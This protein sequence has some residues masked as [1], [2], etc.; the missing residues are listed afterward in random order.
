MVSLHYI[1]INKKNSPKWLPS[2]RPV[3]HF[4]PC[5]P[6][7]F[8]SLHL[9]S[10]EWGGDL[11]ILRA[12]EQ[13]WVAAVHLERGLTGDVWGTVPPLQELGWVIGT[14]AETRLVAARVRPVQVLSCVALSEHVDWH[15]ACTLNRKANKLNR[16][17]L[18]QFQYLFCYFP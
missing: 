11:F 13:G 18:S 12:L 10:A 3:R 4:S 5:L 17:L 6:E 15:D 7:T 9:C 2:I 8:T 1:N 14:V 16:S